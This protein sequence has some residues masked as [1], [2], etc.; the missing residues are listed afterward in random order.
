MLDRRVVCSLAGAVC[1]ALSTHVDARDVRACLTIQDVNQRIECFE[2]RAQ[3]ETLAP[4]PAPTFSPR[5]PCDGAASRI[6]LLICSDSVLVQLDAQM[7]Q[8]YLQALKSQNN[9]ATLAD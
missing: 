4:V 2:G 8:A 1:T 9:S 7:S 6:E 3:P 5:F